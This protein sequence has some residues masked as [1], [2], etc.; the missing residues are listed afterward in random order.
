VADSWIYEAVIRHSHELW[1]TV[2]YMKLF[3]DR[4]LNCGGHLVT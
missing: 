2:G 4:D 3:V 1:S